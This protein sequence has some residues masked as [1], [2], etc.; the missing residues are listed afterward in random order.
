MDPEEQKKIFK[1]A[2][3]EWMDEKYVALGKWSMGMIA[4][5]AMGALAYFILWANGWRQG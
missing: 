5:L 1:E 2:L 3:K 4:A